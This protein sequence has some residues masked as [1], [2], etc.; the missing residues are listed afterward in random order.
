MS[1]RP[2]GP[3]GQDPWDAWRDWSAGSGG[4]AGAGPWDAWKSWQWTPGQRPPMASSFGSSGCAPNAFGFVILIVIAI[5]I[6]SSMLGSVAGGGDLPADDLI[7]AI[8]AL[9]VTGPRDR[10]PPDATAGE[11]ATFPAPG[12]EPAAVA[13][14]IQAVR[15]PRQR[16]TSGTSTFLLYEEATVAIQDVDGGSEIVVFEDNREATRRFPAILIFPGW[17]GSLNDFDTRARSRGGIGGY[18]G[19]GGGLGK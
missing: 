13:D 3:G 15:A 18:R 12:A 16:D 6:I 11:S 17:S 7:A 1:D 14:Q 4:N 5:M 19:G 9:P 2:G 10:R 8:D